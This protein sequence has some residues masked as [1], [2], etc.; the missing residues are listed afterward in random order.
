MAKSRQKI[1]RIQSADQWPYWAEVVCE[2]PLRYERLSDEQQRA[3]NALTGWENPPTRE[4]FDRESPLPKEKQLAIRAR[5]NYLRDKLGI[6]FED[7][8]GYA[9]REGARECLKEP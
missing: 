8:F 1:V 3:L 2:N 5:C 4:D 9:A 6:H 7:L